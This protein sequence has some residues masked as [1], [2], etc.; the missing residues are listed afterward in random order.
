MKTDDQTDAAERKQFRS[1]LARLKAMHPGK[2][3]KKKRRE[4]GMAMYP[5]SKRGERFIPRR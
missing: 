4:P 5:I 2:E 3:G 1:T